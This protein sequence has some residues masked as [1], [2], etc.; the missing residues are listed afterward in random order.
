MRV[1]PA[2]DLGVIPASVALDLGRAALAEDPKADTLWMPCPHWACAEAIDPLEKELGINVVSAHQAITGTH[3]A[4]A[5]STTG[6]T[7]MAA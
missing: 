7:G 5:R 2:V 1:I 3:C 4:D 6:S